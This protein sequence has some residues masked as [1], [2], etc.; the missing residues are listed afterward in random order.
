MDEVLVLAAKR[1]MDSH[2]NSNIKLICQNDN[3]DYI[4]NDK[5]SNVAYECK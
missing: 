3:I 4:E 2:S 1:Y 5:C